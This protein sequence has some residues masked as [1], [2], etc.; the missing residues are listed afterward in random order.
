MDDQPGL[1]LGM[2]LGA[3]VVAPVHL[4]GDTAG[5]SRALRGL[6]REFDALH[7]P[8]RPWSEL[9][10]AHLAVGDAASARSV[11]DRWPE[12]VPED[13]RGEGYPSDRREANLRILL[14]E[15]DAAGS[16]REAEALRRENRCSICVREPLARAYVET[17]RAAEAIEL[18]QE[19]QR[20]VDDAVWHPTDRMR[21]TLL[22]GPLFEE[23]GDTTAAL[24]QYQTI[25]DLWG[26]GD[27]ELQPA[28]RRAQARI[29]ALGA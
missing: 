14:G 7:A 2:R 19:E 25:L 29:A 24:E 22:L 28:V 6:T 10:S 11:Y 23:V 27:P 8:D 15:G 16:A 17:G 5:A 1:A 3:R 13:A 4:A 18:L 20:A 26:G 21:A 9:I 12:E